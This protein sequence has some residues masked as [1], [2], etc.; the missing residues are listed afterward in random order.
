MTLC[1]TNIAGWNITIFNRK[2]Y[3]FN[4]S[5][6]QPAMLDDPGGVPSRVN[7]PSISHLSTRVSEVEIRKAPID[8]EKGVKSTYFLGMS[9]TG[10]KVKLGFQW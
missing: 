4:G 1:E 10:R 9:R 5:V 2:I 3:I 8:S 7:D 6:F